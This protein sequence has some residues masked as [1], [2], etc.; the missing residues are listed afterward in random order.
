MRLIGDG[1]LKKEMSN[2]INKNNLNKYV[3]LFSNIGRKS[4]LKMIAD[5]KLL[6]LPSYFETFGY[7][8]EAYSMGIPVLMTD[9]L[10]V[11]DLH[12]SNC[13]RI[14][15]NKFQYLSNEINDIFK[16]L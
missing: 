7:I 15:K 6:V 5:S 10:G 4:V 3:T 12:N 2:Y 13:S 8:I 9:S 14:I 11:R 1:E 16:E